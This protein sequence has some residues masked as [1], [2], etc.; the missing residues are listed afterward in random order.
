MIVGVFSQS[1][2]SVNTL[3]HANYKPFLSRISFDGVYNLIIIK[4]V[5]SSVFFLSTKFGIFR[6]HSPEAD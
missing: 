2:L 5:L 6:V 3:L 4:H 1:D